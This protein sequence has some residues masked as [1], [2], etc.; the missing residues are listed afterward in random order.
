MKFSSKKFKSAVASVLAL[1]TVLFTTVLAYAE[2]ET[3]GVPVLEDKKIFIG[4]GVFVILLILFSIFIGTRLRKAQDAAHKRWLE[5]HNM[6]DAE[7]NAQAKAYKLQE[8]QRKADLR[9]RKKARKQAM[10]QMKK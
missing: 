4:L 9:A 7:L 1:L 8:K 2:Q 6:T 5:E 3:Y 10:N